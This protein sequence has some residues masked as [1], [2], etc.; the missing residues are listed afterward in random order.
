MSRIMPFRGWRYDLRSAGTEDLNEL[1]APPF[2]VIDVQGQETLY[3]RHRCN[4]IGAILGR[5]EPGDADNKNRYT[6]AAATLH[7]WR[8]SGVLRQEVSPSIYLLRERFGLADGGFTARTG[9][10]FRLRL[11]PWGNGILPHER[12]FPATRADRLALTIA[13]QCQFSPIYALYSDPSAAAQNALISVAERQPDLH[14]QDDDGVEHSL[15]AI[16][17]ASA[18][19]TAIESLEDRTFFIA[20]GHHRYETALNYQRY[21]RYGVLPDAPAPS[22]LTGWQR[23]PDYQDYQPPGPN[24]LQP[25][26]T[27]WIYAARF[28]DPGVVVLPTHRCL[29]GLAD[30]DG[31]TLLDRLGKQFDVTSYSDDSELLEALQSATPG[32]HTYALLLPGSGPGYLLQLRSEHDIRAQLVKQDHP[33]VAAIDAA[34]LQSLIL[35]PL[36]GIARVSGEQKRHITTM[37]SASDAISQTRAG[38]YQAAFLVNPTT[39]KQIEDVSR[40]SQVTPPKTTYFFPKLPSGLLV[41]WMEAGSSP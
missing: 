12:T 37:P 30:F 1:V 26:D 19:Q 16:S 28:E 20:D 10:V 32:D 39:L 15:W 29:N 5:D 25:Y 24:E 14:Y 4:I 38:D 21:R 41:N 9:M 40:A 27:T 18:L 6:R 34:A 11:A 13:T 22:P 36:L 8:A 35:G 2:D 31:E 3:E 23:V 17:R 7:S 33:T